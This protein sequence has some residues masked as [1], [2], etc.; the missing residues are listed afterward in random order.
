MTSLDLADVRAASVGAF[1]RL[2]ALLA[3]SCAVTRHVN[4]INAGT[5]LSCA[6][7]SFDLDTPGSPELD[8]YIAVNLISARSRRCFL[9][10]S[11]TAF[12]I[13]I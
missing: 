5:H 1:M 4:Y 2:D 7:R 3:C 11:P 6:A 9:T 12:V 8:K 10:R 13:L